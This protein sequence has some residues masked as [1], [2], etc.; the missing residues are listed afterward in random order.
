MRPLSRN[1]FEAKRY[2]RSWELQR[3]EQHTRPPR[4]SAAPASTGFTL[5]ETL[6]VVVLMAILASVVL[7][8]S[9]SSANS[10]LRAAASVLGGDI[11]YVQ[12]EAVHTGQTL[13]IDF[14]GDN[15]YRAIGPDINGD[16]QPDLLQH[17][18]ADSPAHYN[19]LK[20]YSEFVVNFD[21]PGPL[22]GVT[23]GSAQFGGKPR[24]EFGKYGEPTSGGEVMLRC[25]GSQVRITVAPATGLV[26]V[27]KLEKAP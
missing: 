27:G 5:V 10:Q 15:E 24:L 14:P 11:Q 8:A 7:P 17:P 26:T 22:R 13:Q 23:I 2:G 19:Q 6:I 1:L 4:P 18:Q 16:G 12:A 25:Q 21:E 20:K 3:H 9:T